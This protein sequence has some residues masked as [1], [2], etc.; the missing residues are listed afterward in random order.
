ML[1][2]KLVFRDQSGRSHVYT[3]RDFQYYGDTL[4]DDLLANVVSCWAPG[5]LNFSQH[6]KGHN[7]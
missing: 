3:K 7:H 2:V 1:I 4:N 5:L 6:C